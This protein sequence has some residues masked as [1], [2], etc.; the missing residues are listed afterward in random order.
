MTTWIQIFISSKMLELAPERQRLYDFL[1][2]LDFDEFRV[3]AW[4]FE[5]DVSANNDSIRRIYL[6]ALGKSHLYVGLFFNDYGEWTI[7]EFECASEWFIPRLIFIKKSTARNSKLNAF[8]D[9]IGDVE[10]GITPAYF[11]TVEDLCSKIEAAIGKWIEEYRSGPLGDRKARI[12]RQPLDIYDRPKRLIGREN[13]L[14]QAINI[15][16]QREPVLLQGFSGSGKTALA[17]EIAAKWI[18]NERQGVLWM[19]VGRNSFDSILEGLT[20]AIDPNQV[21][22]LASASKEDQILKLRD[23]ILQS[24]NSLVVLDDAWNDKALYE[25]V[26]ALP[27]RIALVVTSRNRY[28]LMNNIEVGRLDRFISLQVLDYYAGRQLEDVV[29]GKFWNTQ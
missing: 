25:I 15:L 17:Y 14:D 5:N 12:Y 19:R 22:V 21:K 28:P 18:N 8:L 4:V 7:D 10:T 3:R 23:L 6:E 9:K 24:G 26:Q 16:N 20:V 11:E 2:T 1:P 13:L 27:P 29:R